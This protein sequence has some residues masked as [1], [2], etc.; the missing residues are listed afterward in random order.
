MFQSVILVLFSQDKQNVQ[1][2][3]IIVDFLTKIS[4]NILQNAVVMRNCNY[5]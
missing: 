5:C 2:A 3:Q 4:T 1:F